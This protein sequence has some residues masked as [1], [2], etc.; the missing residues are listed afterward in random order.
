MGV[1]TWS[2]VLVFWCLGDLV[3]AMFVIK[4]FFVRLDVDIR[5]I[6]LIAMPNFGVYFYLIPKEK[7]CRHTYSTFYL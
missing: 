2:T 7:E 1:Y 3:I 6:A 4:Q 5:L